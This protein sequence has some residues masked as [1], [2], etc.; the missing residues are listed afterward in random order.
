MLG[1]EEAVKGGDRI[2]GIWCVQRNLCVLQKFN[3]KK[4]RE[5]V[6]KLVES[7]HLAL[8]CQSQSPVH[9]PP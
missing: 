4:R 9:V 2:G 6:K 3:R 1:R 8:N 5:S 7:Y